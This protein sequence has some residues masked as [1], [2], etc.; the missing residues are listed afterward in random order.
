M[1]C[2][3][4]AKLETL[5][6]K[7]RKIDTHHQ[8]KFRRKRTIDEKFLGKNFLKRPKYY[9]KEIE[10]FKFDLFK[11]NEANSLAVIDLLNRIIH[12]KNGFQIVIDCLSCWQDIIGTNYCLE[13]IANEFIHSNDAEVLHSCL[14]LLNRLLQYAPNAVARIRIDHE[15]KVGIIIF[16]IKDVILLFHMTSVFYFDVIKEINC[17]A[18]YPSIALAY[19]LNVDARIDYIRASKLSGLFG[20]FSRSIDDQIDLWITQHSRNPRSSYEE[21]EDIRSDSGESDEGCSMTSTTATSESL[22]GD[23]RSQIDLILLQLINILKG[24]TNAVCL[25]TIEAILSAICSQTDCD[26]IMNILKNEAENLQNASS[27]VVHSIKPVISSTVLPTTVASPPPPPPPPP[28][29]TVLLPTALANG[30]LQ[31]SKGIQAPPA[32]PPPLNLRRSDNEKKMEIPKAL[33]LKSLPREGAK[34]KQIQWTKIPA[35]KIL[36]FDSNKVENVWMSLAKLPENEFYL[37]FDELESMF[38]CGERNFIDTTTTLERKQSRK[39][40]SISLLCHKRSFNVSIFLRQFKEEYSHYVKFMRNL[41][42]HLWPIYKN[43][44]GIALKFLNL[45][46]PE[47]VI[48]NIKEGKGELIGYERLHTLQTILPD[49]E[50]MEILRG[51]SGDITQLGLAEQFF[52]NLTTVNDYSLKLNCLILKEE[53]KNIFNIVQPQIDIILTALSEIKDSESL[54]KIFCILL[55]VGNFLNANGN[56]GN[57]IGFRLN[58]LWKIIDMKAAKQSL[59]LIHFI[60]TK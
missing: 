8:S 21:N 45:T 22:S 32:P 7:Y 54:R 42:P 3:L 55:Q 38:S 10:N 34:L 27:K 39:N 41:K 36:D 49:N 60:A 24:E 29:Q 46:G 2:N 17:F 11:L 25:T 58:S 33:R 44:I 19:Q 43:F 56:C 9:F 16:K 30:C 40:E 14:T 4:N 31:P 37:N 53:L 28:P 5:I 20:K 59:T 13:T 57:A 12:K 26:K 50:E 15:L 23:N 52:L 18:Y 48:E 47:Q 1:I 6:E 35:E 51:F